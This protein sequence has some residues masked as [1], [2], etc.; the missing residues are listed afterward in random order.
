[1]LKKT[2]TYDDFDDN[3]VTEDFYFNLSKADLAEMELS[4]KGGL[5]EYIKK[6][7]AESDG[8][9]LVEIFKEL[10][11][12]SVGRRSEDGRRFIKNQEIVDDFTQ[13]NAYSELF[14]ELATNADQ[15]AA[16]INGIIPTSMQEAAK[17]AA[18]ESLELPAV[19]DTPEAIREPSWITDGRV[20][21]PAELKNATP[22][23]IS[24]AFQRKQAESNTNTVA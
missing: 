22:E 12:K 17:A 1:M 13:T 10:L 8:A 7:I 19:S 18:A 23:Q 4:Q 6:I 20:P 21:T 16:F 14:V 9:K 15:G 11:L 2:I 3:S 24:L 5:E